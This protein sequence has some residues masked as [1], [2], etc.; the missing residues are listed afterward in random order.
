MQTS[1]QVGLSSQIAL[2][3]R[4]ETIAHNIANMNTAGFR[5]DEVRFETI[6]SRA[7]EKDVSFAAT[8]DT[9]ISRK[10]GS[11]VKTDNPLDVA[12]AGDA[13]LG[14]QT[15]SGVAY[16]RDGRLTMKESGEIVTVT[17]NAVLD[18]GG[19]GLTLDPN[20]GPVSISREGTIHQ[21]GRQVGTLGLFS[22]ETAAK[23]ARSDNS[24][25]IPDK[26]AAPVQNFTRDGI[27]Q[28]F[29]EDANVNPVL[30]MT[31]LIAVQRNFDSM[32]GVI[33]ASDTSLSEAI[34]TLGGGG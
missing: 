10:S 28:G 25:V 30:E 15:K 32:T 21:G 14:I 11:M 13:W 34:K 17:G 9:F 20:G 12:V 5:A 18:S 19:S 29:V 1:L 4:L 33:D 2:Q 27:V 31:R 16:T 22:I 26:P 6:L 24:G 23:L 7:S 8:G 3:K